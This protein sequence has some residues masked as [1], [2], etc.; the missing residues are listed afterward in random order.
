[1]RTLFHGTTLE[2]YHSILEHGFD[3]EL[4]SSMVW[5]VSD[6]DVT[7]FY[8]SSKEEANDFEECIYRCLGNAQI[9][10]S[11][12]RYIGNELVVM[13]LEVE[14]E[15]CSNDLSCGWETE[16]ATVV[17]NMELD[18]SMIKKVYVSD[19]A[20]NPFLRLYFLSV[21]NDNEF[22]VKECITVNELLLIK[23]IEGTYISTDDYS[24]NVLK[25]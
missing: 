15:I 25:D 13:Q 8:D 20:Y 23:K 7:Y 6:S 22:L 16:V 21:M 17:H 1:M 19:D 18:T 2:N 24:W 10:A 4:A 12:Q 11:V 5:N 3:G 14:D 9:T